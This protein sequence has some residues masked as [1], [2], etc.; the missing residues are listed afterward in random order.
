MA[1]LSDYI[2]G[3]ITLTNGSPDFTGT[4]TGW[5]AAGFREGD[6]ILGIEGNPGVEYVIASIDDNGEGTLTQDW[7]GPSGTYAYRMRY[8]ADGARV[9]AQARNLIEMLGNGNLQALAGLTGPGVP[10]FNGPHSMEVRPVTDFINGVAYNVQVDTLADRAAYDGQS[11]GFAVLV[12]DVGDG[13]SALYTKNSNTVGDWSDPA[14]L[15]GPEGEQGIPGP[16]GVNWRGAYNAGTVYA[17]GDGVAFNGSSFVK[18]T[19]AGAGN[20]PS[21]AV[22]PAD[23]ANWAVIAARGINGSGTGDVVGPA[24]ATNNRLA[25]FDGATGKLIKDAGYTIAQ[26][27]TDPINDSRI[28]ATLTPDKAFRRGNVLGTVSQSGGTPTGALIESGTN[29]NGTYVRFADGTQICWKAVS[30]N[31]AIAAHAYTSVAGGSWAAAFVAAPLPSLQYRG[32]W[33]PLFVAGIDG[34]TAAGVSGNLTLSNHSNIS[35]TASG[36]I[37]IVATGRWFT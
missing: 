17:I 12:S 11:G 26:V 2:A 22:P 37:S 35:E 32:G 29:A 5:L 3:T 21:G 10:V 1:V 34:T 27:A 18:L 23:N 4:G 33:A 6:T 31:Q 25:A 15:T 7:D 8:L 24:S 9:T 20:A 14:Y 28:N 36:T 30:I 19:T 16:V 13:R